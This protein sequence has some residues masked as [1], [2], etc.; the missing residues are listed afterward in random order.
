[1]V[2]HRL[3]WAFRQA[4]RLQPDARATVATQVAQAGQARRARHITLFILLLGLVL[5]MA[6]VLIAT[7]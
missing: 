2:R 3:Q 4:A 5:L 6:G 1:M 7:I